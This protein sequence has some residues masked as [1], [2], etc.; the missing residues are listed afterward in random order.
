MKYI[1]ANLKNSL[2]DNNVDKY[3]KVISE[4]KYKNLIICPQ[5]KYI[6][7]FKNIVNVGMQDYYSDID[8]RYC[9][10]GHYE[11]KN[12]NKQ[13]NKKIKKALIN[14]INVI[15]CVGNNDYDDLD[16]IKSQLDDYLDEIND[17]KRISI[18]Y[19]PYFMINNDIDIDYKKVKKNIDYIKKYFNNKINVFYGGNVNLESIE[20]IIN[21]CDGVLLGR[22]SFNPY[23]LTNIL[24]YIKNCI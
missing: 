5:K 6:N 9:I 13:I 17:I 19:E 20:K 10:I 1:V 2:T 12:S 14:N 11:R 4:N 24:K 22:S 16:N 7:N 15:L 18:A 23:N 21:I 3:I 8:A